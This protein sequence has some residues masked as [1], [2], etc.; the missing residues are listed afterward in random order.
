LHGLAMGAAFGL[1][2][3]LTPLFVVVPLLGHLGRE[4]VT[5][6]PNLLV[7]MRWTGALILVALG[8]R[9]ILLAW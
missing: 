8:L 6:H 3:A 9:R 7:W 1:G 5:G 2:A 4:M